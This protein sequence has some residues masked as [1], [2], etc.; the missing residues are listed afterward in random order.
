MT[1]SWSY[2]LPVTWSF[3]RNWTE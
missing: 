3:C 1:R 2:L